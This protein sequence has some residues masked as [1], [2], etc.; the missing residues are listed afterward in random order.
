MAF[1]A[2]IGTSGLQNQVRTVVRGCRCVV[3]HLTHS[4]C[5][6]E[7]CNAGARRGASAQGSVAAEDGRWSQ[8]SCDC[9]E[10]EAGGGVA[11][12]GDYITAWAYA[13][14]LTARLE[15]LHIAHTSLAQTVSNRASLHRRNGHG[16]NGG[17]GPEA[18]IGGRG[19][20]R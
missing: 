3:T 7:E 8:R 6:C 10:C 4:G 1:F 17:D 19:P 5:G 9:S 16:H 11:R 14:Q 20:M 15:T 2:S 18:H 13:S 12:N